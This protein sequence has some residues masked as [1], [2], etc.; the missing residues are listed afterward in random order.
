MARLSQSFEHKRLATCMYIDATGIIQH[1]TVLDR[2]GPPAG[3][4][5]L[6]T[7]LAIAGRT[8][9]AVPAHCKRLL[10]E[11][12]QADTCYVSFPTSFSQSVRRI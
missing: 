1:V 4:A 2:M 10:A 9:F 5:S 3:L 11:S 6:T 12:K 7:A 8:V